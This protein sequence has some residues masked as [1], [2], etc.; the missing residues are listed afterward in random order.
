MIDNEYNDNT[1]KVIIS[2]LHAAKGL[3]FDVVFLPGWEEGLFPH[4]KCIDC[5]DDNSIEEERRLAYVAITRARK[6]LYITIAFQRRLYGQTQINTPSRFINELPPACIELINNT[7]YA[8]PQKT[9]DYNASYGGG[10][11]YYQ[12]N[13]GYQNSRG[14]YRYGGGY[15]GYNSYKKKEK[16][17]Y[18]D[19]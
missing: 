15:S 4:Q 3:E 12:N 10:R 17:S 7:G 18:F 2:T 16:H 11:N 8:A 5:G 13:D 6:L 1:N 19:R 14:G 9:S